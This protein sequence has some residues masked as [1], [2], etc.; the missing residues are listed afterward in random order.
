MTDGE[1]VL[2][3]DG[4]WIRYWQRFLPATEVERLLA[5]LRDNVRWEQFRNHLWTFPRLTAFVAD[6][7]IAYRYSG[8][9]HTGGGW[10][11]DLLAVRRQVE[12]QSGVAFNGVLLNLYR[13]GSD[14]MGRHA[15]AEPELGR[16]PVVASVSLG[17]VRR[18]VLRHRLGGE[19]RSLE[20]AS[21]S[22]L[23]MGGTLQ[24]H[25][26]HELPKTKEAV[27]ARINLTFRNFIAP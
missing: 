24:H 2:L 17:A 15:D 8:V 16:N 22:L 1:R 14:S 20:L 11:A 19:T 27:G 26:Q 23:L 21:G 5:A 18:F 7:G 25:W 4:G 12:R 6:A 3:R 13:D 10:P 9:I